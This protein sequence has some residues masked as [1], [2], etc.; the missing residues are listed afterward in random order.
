MYER[1]EEAMFKRI[2]FVGATLTVAGWF[3]VSPS[4]ATKD[5]AK[6]EGKTCVTC[7]V[8]SGDKEL[9]ELGLYYQ[10]HKTLKGFKK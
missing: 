9:N 5:V 1:K 10:E 8:K 4:M 7:H 6:K 2:L 3:V